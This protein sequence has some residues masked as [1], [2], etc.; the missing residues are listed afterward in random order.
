MTRT[1]IST[2]A[3]PAAIGSYSQAIDTG[4]IVYLSG[5]IGLDP[6]TMD[7]VSHTFE[8][9]ILQVFRNLAS[10][11]AASGGSLGSVVKTTVFLTDLKLFEE[12]NKVFTEQFTRPFPAR[13]VVGVS[14]LPRGARVEIEAVLSI[15]RQSS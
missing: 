5:Q 2:Q 15:T 3:A 7:L 1:A 6:A 12:V 11:C 8:A 4:E 13:S 9:E 14:E 10:V